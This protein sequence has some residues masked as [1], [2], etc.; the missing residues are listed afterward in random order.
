VT[1]GTVSL[2]GRAIMDPVEII[3][4]RQLDR[5][6]ARPLTFILATVGISL[7]ASFSPR[8]TSRIC[9]TTD[10]SAPVRTGGYYVIHGPLASSP[11]A[12]GL[13]VGTIGG[14]SSGV[15]NHRHKLF[16]W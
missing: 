3:A 15:R 12:M 10:Q 1:S 2:F 7:V 9:A 6:A 4:P 8:S 11:Q 5:G 13:F 14:F 16:T